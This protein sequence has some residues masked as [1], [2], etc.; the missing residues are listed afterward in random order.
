MPARPRTRPHP[1]CRDGGL[2]AQLK[3]E[4][5]HNVNCVE[6]WGKKKKPPESAPLALGGG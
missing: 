5:K 1:E 6:P 2:A 3:P 4:Q